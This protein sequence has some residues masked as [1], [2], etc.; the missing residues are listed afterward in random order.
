MTTKLGG[1]CFCGSVEFSLEDNFSDF[2][3]CHCRQCQQLSGSAFTSNLFTAPENIEW[4]KGAD[5]IKSYEHPSRE[6]ATSFCGSAV[7][8]LNKSRSSLIVPAGSLNNFPEIRPQANMFTSEEVCW[9]KPGQKLRHA[10]CV[11]THKIHAAVN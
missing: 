1:G 3:Q 8:F 2:Y 4:T 6:F 5:S 9:L 11:R 10:A 7:P